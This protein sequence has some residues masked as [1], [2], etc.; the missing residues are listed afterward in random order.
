MEG[1]ACRNFYEQGRYAEAIPGPAYH[2]QS[3]GALFHKNPATT[4]MQNSLENDPETKQENSRK[5]MKII[6]V[7]TET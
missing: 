1:T 6:N 4:V 2:S 3:R 5:E 7:L